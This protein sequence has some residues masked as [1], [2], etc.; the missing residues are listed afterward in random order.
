MLIVY[1]NPAL[2]EPY[3]SGTHAREAL[4]ELRRADGISV[5]EF[6]KE[7][8]GNPEASLEPA[9]TK[10][11]SC[12]RA[13]MCIFLGWKMFLKDYTPTLPSFDSLQGLPIVVFIRTNLR[14]RLIKF[15]RSQPKVSL[16]CAEVNAIVTEETPE[17]LPFRSLWTRIEIGFLSH[18]HRIMVV[19]TY[20][21]LRLV[22]YGHNPDHILVNPNGANTQ[23]FDPTRFRNSGELR[24]S[25]NIPDHA[26]IFGYVGGMQ[27]FRNLPE[28][29][30]TF[31]EFASRSPDSYLVLVGGGR[32]SEKIRKIRASLPIEIGKRVILLGVLPFGQVPAAMSA[33]DCG[34]FP[35]TN[36][37]CSPLKIFEYLAMGLPVIGPKVPG[38]TEIFEDGAH[39]RLA[40]QDGSNLLELF[41]EFSVRPAG[42]QQMAERGRSLVLENYTW[43]ANADRLCGFLRQS[44]MELSAPGK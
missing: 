26:Y 44:L 34:I 19:S 42:N 7:D 2:T 20:L 17:W 22:E 32:D 18:S 3:G 31:S 5:I 1:Y 29:V 35:F 21:K 16:V 13:P 37:Y 43:K 14:I 28:V 4:Q 36:P 6:P 40:E 33:F 15:I 41:Q 12:L 23:H 39:L 10:P 24:E 9:I 30:R 25:W 27:T 8:S 38:V 11:R